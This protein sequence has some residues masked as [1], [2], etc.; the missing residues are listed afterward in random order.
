MTGAVPA[1]SQASRL[2]DELLQDDE[3]PIVGVMTRLVDEFLFRA[4]LGQARSREDEAVQSMLKPSV[5]SEII[6][7]FFP[8][9]LTPHHVYN[10]QKSYAGGRKGAQICVRFRK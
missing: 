9:L 2:V 7:A 4:E 10:V 5:V 1:S 8:K 6:H 3:R